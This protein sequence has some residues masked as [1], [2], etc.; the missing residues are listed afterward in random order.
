MTTRGNTMAD[1]HYFPHDLSN[2][3]LMTAWPTPQSSDMTGGGQAKRSD[4]RA[5]LND[6][7]ML[8]G[9]PTPTSEDRKSDGPKSTARMDAGMP[10]LSDLRLRNTALLAGWGT[11]V[12]RDWKSGE[13]SQETL[14]KNARPLNELA[15]LA[16]W[17]TPMAQTPAQN[18]N[19]EAGNSDSSRKTVEMCR[20]PVDPSTAFGETP[21]GFLLG[22]NGWEIVPASGQLNASH[23]RWLMGLPEIWDTA[24]NSSFPLC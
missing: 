2:A 5:N 15:K 22:R 17:P 18:G 24:E 8:A 19:N 23:S 1:G 11:P 14:G 10:L 16:G 4:G 6:F 3:V 21:I 13:A 20:W 9:W 7:A 12:A